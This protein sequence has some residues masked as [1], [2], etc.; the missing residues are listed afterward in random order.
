VSTRGNIGNIFHSSF[1]L[2]ALESHVVLALS[3]V[4]KWA[5]EGKIFD[6][7]LSFFES[8]GPVRHSDPG[9]PFVQG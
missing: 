2:C 3:L 5:S 9:T 6:D 1:T 4:L 7:V 8:P